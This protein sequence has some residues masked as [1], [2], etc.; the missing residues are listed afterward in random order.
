MS[1]P[2]FTVNFPAL[3]GNNLSLAYLAVTF[4]Q[5]LR[6]TFKHKIINQLPKYSK[7][8]KKNKAMKTSIIISTIATVCLMITITENPMNRDAQNNTNTLYSNI[9]YLPTNTV[10][11]K[12]EVML[13]AF[14]KENIASSTKVNVNRDFSYL[15]FNAADYTEASGE[16]AEVNDEKSFEYLKFDVTKYE[17]NN[18]NTS[19]ET[20]EMPINEF[21]YLKFDVNDYNPTVNES[22]ELPVNEFENLKFNVNDYTT[23]DNDQSLESP[24]ND[25]D[26]LKFD[27]NKYSCNDQVTDQDAELPVTE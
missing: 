9:S 23:A 15:K 4:I 16:K 20:I 10:S 11:T 19:V 24:A 5:L 12:T 13:P 3:T 7:E 2:F 17:D 14:T 1:I 21:D 22:I 25:F 18:R 6:H 26:Y 27:V 8:N